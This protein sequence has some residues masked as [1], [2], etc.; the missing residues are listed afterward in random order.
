MPDNVP[1]EAIAAAAIRSSPTLLG[2][3]TRI[4]AG[5]VE[6]YG[7]EGR[8]S[9]AALTKNGRATLDAAAPLHCAR[10]RQ[11]VLDRLT[12]QQVEQLSEISRVLLDGLEGAGTTRGS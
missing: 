11:L 9:Y 8:A 4:V 5:L 12:A 7:D 10:V 1:Q 6:R 3:V 2:R